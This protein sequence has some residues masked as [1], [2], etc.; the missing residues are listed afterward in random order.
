M[1]SIFTLLGNSF[2]SLN[3][4][5]SCKINGLG[6]GLTL[7]VQRGEVRLILK[8]IVFAGGGGGGEGGSGYET[9]TGYARLKV[10]M[11]L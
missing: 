10:R 6:K 3:V 7:A 4:L 2:R 11:V 9:R 8:D 1:D 5:Y